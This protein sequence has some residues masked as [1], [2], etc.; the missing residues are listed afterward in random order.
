[1]TAPIVLVDRSAVEAV[2]LDDVHFVPHGT[3][4]PSTGSTIGLRGEMARFSSS[5]RHAAR[6]STVVAA[7]EGLDVEQAEAIARELSEH[8]VARGDDDDEI[9]ASV[10]TLTIVEL[11]GWQGERDVILDDVESIVRVIGRGEP[12][13]PESDAAT[14]RLTSRAADHPAGAVAV[15]SILYQNFDATAAAVRAATTARRRRT[16]AEPAV[17][18]TRRTASISTVV[19]G[20]EVEPEVDVVLEIGAAG[21]PYGAGPHECPGRVPAE[22]I[23]AGIVGVVCP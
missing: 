20:L 16:S 22:R 23:V 12:A 3:D 2:L 17:A 7:I 21:L 11:L 1:M 14:D 19:D 13:T 18:R 4:D 8:A 10:P 9:A 15:L 6:R 5:S